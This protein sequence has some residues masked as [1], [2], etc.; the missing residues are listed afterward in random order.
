M[1]TDALL[2]VGAQQS[3]LPREWTES[4]AVWRLQVGIYILQQTHHENFSTHVL[5]GWLE[6]FT[7]R[8]Q[9]SWGEGRATPGTSGQFIWGPHSKTGNRCHYSHT[10]WQCRVS[11]SPENQRKHKGGGNQTCNL[12]AARWQ[13]EPLHNVSLVSPLLLCTSELLSIR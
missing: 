3:A 4:I 1:Y 11:K 2:I 7:Q 8:L 6:L 10:Y 13:R 9:L 5:Y 12:L